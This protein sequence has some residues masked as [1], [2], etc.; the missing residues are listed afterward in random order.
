MDCVI[1]QNRDILFLGFL[2][3]EDETDRL[4]RNVVQELSLHAAKYPR[5]ARISNFYQIARCD[6]PDG[7]ILRRPNCYILQT[8]Y[9]L[10]L[11]LL[12]SSKERLGT[13]GLNKLLVI[14]SRDL[15]QKKARQN[16]SFLAPPIQSNC[17][18]VCNQQL[19]GSKTL[20][21]FHCSYSA[22]CS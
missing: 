9:T 15:T 2:A 13:A 17:R 18:R 5:R 3:L 11:S 6:I 10:F 20:Y 14:E 1:S 22:F 4:C 16:I 21:K 19:L 12:F 7:N 8:T